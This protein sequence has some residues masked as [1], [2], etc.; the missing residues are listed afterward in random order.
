MPIAIRGHPPGIESNKR[1]LKSLK[2]NLTVDPSGRTTVSSS[3]KFSTVVV[4][5]DGDSTTTGSRSRRL[6]PEIR[7]VLSVGHAG[8]VMVEWWVGQLLS[9]LKCSSAF[10]VGLINFPTQFLSS[11]IPQ[12]YPWSWQTSRLNLLESYRPHKDRSA[13]NSSW[14]LRFLIMTT[15]GGLGFISRFIN[16]IASRRTRSKNGPY[17]CIFFPLRF[18]PSFLVHGGWSWGDYLCQRVAFLDTFSPSLWAPKH[19]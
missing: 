3:G 18:M 16:P 19:S 7:G 6:P 2:S 17:L 13:F 1:D 15:W 4:D 5:D 12:K 14:W 10:L 8:S 9:T 11:V